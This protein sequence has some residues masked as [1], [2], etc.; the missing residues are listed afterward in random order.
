MAV[1]PRQIIAT[2]KLRIKQGR[3]KAHFPAA[4][5]Y[6]PTIFAKKSRCGSLCNHNGNWGNNRSMIALLYQATT[7]LPA[8]GR[9][10][11][12]IGIASPYWILTPAAVRLILI[13]PFPVQTSVSMTILSVTVSKRII[14][15][16]LIYQNRLYSYDSLPATMPLETYVLVL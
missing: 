1:L 12:S 10:A 13:L 16:T 3:R 9:T 15:I 8:A 11:G 7:P 14:C 6:L 4:L 5:F 2:F